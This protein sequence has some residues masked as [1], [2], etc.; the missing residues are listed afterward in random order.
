MRR[1]RKWLFEQ[2]AALPL[3]ATALVAVL[4]TYLLR[5]PLLL[6]R[7]FDP[8]EFEHL[9]GAWAITKGLVPYRDFFEHHTP[10]I[11]FLLAPLF[12]FFD[13]ETDVAGAFGLV[14]LA[15]RL[16]WVFAGALL[17]LTWWLGRI[18][19]DDRVAAAGTFFLAMTV[20]FLEKTLEVRPDVVSVPL[21]LASLGATCRAIQ[22]KHGDDRGTRLHFAVGGICLGAGVMF[23][24]KLLFALPGFGVAVAWYVLDRRSH[25]TLSA[26]CTNVL[27][28]MAGF[29]LP[30]LVVSAYFAAVGGLLPF[31]DDN[32]LLNLR[33]K[34]RFQ[35]YGYLTQLLRQNPF[36]VALGVAGLVRQLAGMARRER[37]LRGDAILPLSTAG[38]I[39]CLWVMPVPYRQYYLMF[40]PLLALL[41]G[42]LLV[43]GLEVADAALR[44]RLQWRWR[45]WVGA[46]LV[47][48]VAALGL[49]VAFRYGKPNLGGGLSTAAWAAAGGGAVILLLLRLRYLAGAVL[50]VVLSL[51][52]LQQM[53]AAFGWKNDATLT[54]LRYVLENTSPHETT[55]DGWTGRGVF[56]PHAYFY[57]FLH[58]EIRAM[59]P[60][61]ERERLLEDLRAGRVAPALLFLD[62]NLRELSPEVTAFFEER[63]EPVGLGP[64]WRRR[65]PDVP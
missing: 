7:G 33:W 44:G 38:L 19:R 24:Q 8:D 3:L 12:L 40:L 36:L 51:Y 15:R 60:A 20:M 55:M 22:E 27:V 58:P 59:L 41:A 61:G 52:P 34:V 32:F 39:A 46:V 6:T 64:I 28:Q 18:W 45:A 4:T 9:H 35:P 31:L 13:V 14:F 48:G 16:M 29:F 30:I 42:G 54:E 5:L 23:T 21:W 47:A 17:A 2:G 25:A 1:V 56:R 53:H 50:L 37:F 57:F 43:E 49:W 63:Y 65:E 62:G 26:R 10:G 11:H